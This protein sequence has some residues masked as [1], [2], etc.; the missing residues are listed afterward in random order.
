M[1]AY[2]IQQFRT[3][4]PHEDACLR[5]LFLSRHPTETPCPKCRHTGS[6]RRIKNRPAY[7]CG[8]CGNQIYPM[9]GT[10]YEKSRT[11]LMYWYYALFLFVK[12]KRGL[13]AKELQRQLGVT[14]KTAHRMLMQIRS[15][16]PPPEGPLDGTVEID[17]TFV[18]GR[19][20]N[21][22]AH[23]KAPRAQGRNFMDKTPVLGAL[24]RNGRVQATVVPDTSAQSLQPVVRRWVKPGAH[25]I[26]DEWGGYKGLSAIYVHSRVYHSRKQ[27]ANGANSTNGIENFWSGLKRTLGCYIRVSRKHLQ[28]YVDECVYRFNQR[29]N[30][31]I[32][33]DLLGLSFLKR[34]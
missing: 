24:Q 6:Y 16:L 8:K 29:N 33:R 22:H 2:T 27:Y 19:N 11:P 4:Y 31:F 30:P 3:Q 7:Q 26:T 18:G 34:L 32:F 5:H 12:S 20:K 25:I 28:K 14:Y 13:T 9:K 1:C 21:R 17:E 10:I 23:K 15:A